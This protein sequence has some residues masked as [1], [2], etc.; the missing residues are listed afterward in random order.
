MT[1]K[2]EIFEG[3]LLGPYW[4]CNCGSWGHSERAQMQCR[5]H[6]NQGDKFVITFVEGWKHG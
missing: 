4:F 1:H 6:M 3:G 2:V 5:G